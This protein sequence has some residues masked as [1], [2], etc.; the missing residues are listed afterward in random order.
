M[1]TH[2]G[3]FKYMGTRHVWKQLWSTQTSLAHCKH[4]NQSTVSMALC[5]P[6][7]DT[8]FGLFISTYYNSKTTGTEMNRN[9]P[10]G[11]E[12]FSHSAAV[13]HPVPGI[14]HCSICCT[15]LNAR[16]DLWLFKSASAQQCNHSKPL[17]NLLLKTCKANDSNYFNHRAVFEVRR[18]RIFT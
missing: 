2:T 8:V 14:W 10:D 15:K 11:L 9:P 18:H 3:N 17:G 6:Q 13:H 7:S 4:W 16:V 12:P 5:W 1:L